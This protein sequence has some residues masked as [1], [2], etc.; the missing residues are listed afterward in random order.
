MVSLWSNEE[1]RLKKMISA[2]SEVDESVL[3]DMEKWQAKANRTM[4][5]KKQLPTWMLVQLC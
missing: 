3:A 2:T 4:Q 5:S 1:E